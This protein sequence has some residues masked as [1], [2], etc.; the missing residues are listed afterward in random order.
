MPA[1][2]LK[3]RHAKAATTLIDE[4]LRGYLRAQQRILAARAAESRRA[5]SR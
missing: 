1:N 5:K 2:E 3:S 4:I